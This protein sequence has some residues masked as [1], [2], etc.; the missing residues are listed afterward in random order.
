MSAF[1]SWIFIINNWWLFLESKALNDIREDV[2]CTYFSPIYSNTKLSVLVV[3][4]DFIVNSFDLFVCHALLHYLSNL[5]FFPVLCT[6]SHVYLFDCG[7]KEFGHRNYIKRCEWKIVHS[8]SRRPT[9]RDKLCGRLRWSQF[10]FDKIFDVYKG[11]YGSKSKY[12]SRS[13]CNSL[14]TFLDPTVSSLQNSC[15]PS[16][17]LMTLLNTKIKL[18]PDI[19]VIA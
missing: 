7:G 2:C 5:I 8:H 18:F 19:N 9:R 13:C 6:S 1:A 3:I 16:S 10:F 15:G 14:K 11:L 12:R 4:T 17:G